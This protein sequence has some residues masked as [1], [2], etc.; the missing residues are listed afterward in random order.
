MK[1][2]THGYLG[3]VPENTLMTYFLIFAM[4]KRKKLILEENIAKNK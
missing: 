3:C 1:L 2:I 4:L